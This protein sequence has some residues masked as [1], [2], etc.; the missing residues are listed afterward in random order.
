MSLVLIV[1]AAFI[2]GFFTG[3]LFM[4]ARLLTAWRRNPRFVMS[5]LDKNA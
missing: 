2:L 1:L 4:S 5:V 3:V